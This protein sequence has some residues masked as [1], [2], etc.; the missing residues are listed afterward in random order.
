MSWFFHDPF[1]SLVGGLDTQVMAASTPSS[2]KSK[3]HKAQISGKIKG[4]LKLLPFTTFGVVVHFF[5][6][7]FLVINS[8]TFGRFKL[9]HQ[10]CCTTVFHVEIRNRKR[11]DS[12]GS[13]FTMSIFHHVM[14]V[15]RND[16]KQRRNQGWTTSVY[17]CQRWKWLIFIFIQLGNLRIFKQTVGEL[18]RVLFKKMTSI[19]MA[20]LAAAFFL[21][22]QNPKNIP[23]T[24]FPG[25]HGAALRV[26]CWTRP[27]NGSTWTYPKL[28][29]YTAYEKFWGPVWCYVFDTL[30]SVSL[31]SLKNVECFWIVSGKQQ[32]FHAF[33]LY[34]I[35]SYCG[36][37]MY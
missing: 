16:C 36:F 6:W 26:W 37:W 18:L 27:R 2:R 3:T 24:G 17:R 28:A 25:S 20:L 10:I 31:T 22:P 15:F 12:R 4:H 1:R 30:R 19:R 7:Q 9:P 23:P 13:F 14:C 34:P 33:Q 5:S 8:H 21:L 29:S 32:R 35:Q 11:W